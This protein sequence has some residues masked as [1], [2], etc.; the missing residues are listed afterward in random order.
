M[1]FV[2]KPQQTAMSQPDTLLY[3]R[4]GP[5]NYV[6]GSGMLAEL[7]DHYTQGRTHVAAITGHAS[8]EAF[9]RAVGN[10]DALGGA[11]VHRYDGTVSAQD[12]GRLAAETAGS[13]LIVAIGGGRVCDT[14]KA[15]AARL[16]SDIVTVPTI[17]A[18]CAAY[19]SHTVIYNRHHVKSGFEQ[20]DHSPLATLV[21][22][23]LLVHAPERTLIAGIG[24][25]IAKWYEAKA[26]MRPGTRIRP[27][28]RLGLIAA[29]NVKDL[30]LE[31]AQNAI[32][33]NQAGEETQAFCDAVEAIFTLS[34]SVG[35]FANRKG[36]S[37]GAHATANAITALPGS[38]HS[39]HGEQVAYGILVLL[40]V[41]G[42]E[43]NLRLLR[44][45]YRQIG[46]PRS[47]ADLGIDASDDN[48][49][50]VSAVAASPRENFVL[51]VP[52]ITPE[53]IAHAMRAVAQGAEEEQVPHIVGQSIREM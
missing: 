22:T 14:A 19:S 43:D 12:I 21:D 40:T 47:L 4:S 18:T 30:L 13:D 28:E 46:L 51:A 37:S 31:H 3:A 9:R 25:S 45:W 7:I 8:Y 44:D 29:E 49:R 36:R 38:E 50:T 39:L 53:Q 33:A 23:A 1:F 17:A 6:Q 32:A 2:R 27:T 41:L 15:V 26:I 20:H 24:D 48:I 35:G 42:D 34:G 52:G 11:S 16:G 5:D 10:T